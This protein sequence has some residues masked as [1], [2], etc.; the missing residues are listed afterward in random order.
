[1]DT[2]IGWDGPGQHGA[3]ARQGQRS[4]GDYIFKKHAFCGQSVD[5]RGGFGLVAIAT[6]MVGP[7]SVNA[8]QDDAIYTMCGPN[9]SPHEP[10]TGRNDNSQQGDQNHK[11]FDMF[12][13]GF[14]I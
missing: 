10:H 3:V 7:A 13:L 4:R 2:V 9:G 6:E 11:P 14:P 8:D 12:H 1:M 5:V